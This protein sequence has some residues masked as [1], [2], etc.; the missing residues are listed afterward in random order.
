MRQPARRHE[1]LAHHASVRIVSQ[2]PSVVV[3][4]LPDRSTAQD[5]AE[6]I[7]VVLPGAQ[8]FIDVAQAPMASASRALDA[9]SAA[10]SQ[11]TDPATTDL[12]TDRVA[13]YAVVWRPD[14]GFFHRHR[15]LKAVFAA[16]AGV[17]QLLRHP[18]LPAQLPVHRIEDA[19]MA[20]QM[21][22]YCCHEVL[23][24]HY[25]YD[26]YESQQRERRWHDWPLEPPAERT[27]GVFGLGVLGAEVARSLLALGFS[28]RAYSRSPR[29]LPG[30]QCFDE[31]QG[32]EAFLSGCQSLILL[33]PLTPHTRDLFDARRLGCL[34]RGASLINVA[35]GALVVDDDL[36]AALDSGHLASATL[37]VFREEPLPATHRFWDHPRV[38]LTP[39]IAAITVVADSARQVAGKIA[40]LESG[41][42]AGG[43]IDRARGY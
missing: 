31:R 17:D 41:A 15:S 13:D 9:G 25:R 32:L 1:S 24:L 29:V 4:A 20:Q 37:D 26:R 28:V 22:A 34:P 40:R 19:G 21:A 43:L 14:S 23:R 12:A 8:V 3:V 38:R 18:A 7:R 16:G 5:W 42:P 6:A 10:A 11:P 27:V 30:V 33:A 35:R 39:H 2:R 36:L